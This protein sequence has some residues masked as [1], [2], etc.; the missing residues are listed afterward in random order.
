MRVSRRPRGLFG[1]IAAAVV[2]AGCGPGNSPSA[3]EPISG[4][5]TFEGGLLEAGTIQ[6]Q[7][8]SRAEGVA[9]GGPITAGRF[10]IP[11]VEGPV[12]GKYK[13]AIFATSAD[14]PS[15]GSAEAVVPLP[16]SRDRSARA[17]GIPPR[18]NMNSE[19]TADVKPGGPNT[20]TFDLAK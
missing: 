1:T 9:S 19:L 4:T 8:A 3:R 12:P 5:V 6:F 18:Y 17:A 11:R 13:V 2:M 14:R 15:G 10:D 16:R 20:F 7:P